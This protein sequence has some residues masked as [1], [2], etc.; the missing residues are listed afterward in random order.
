MFKG[1]EKDIRE[2]IWN[3]VSDGLDQLHEDTMKTFKNLMTKEGLSEE[4]EMIKISLENYYWLI[5]NC[6][7]TEI[8]EDTDEKLPNPIGGHT[9]N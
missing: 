3:D 9:I 6:L 7:Q 4:A 1:T 5:R 2:A 8:L